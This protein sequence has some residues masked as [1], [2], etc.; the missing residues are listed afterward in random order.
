MTRAGYDPL[1]A[2]NPTFNRLDSLAQ[3]M[4]S[5]Y[6]G[7]VTFISRV[8]SGTGIEPVSTDTEMTVRAYTGGYSLSETDG[9]LIQSGDVKLIIGSEFEPEPAMKVRLRDNKTYDVISVES[10]KPDGIA[11]YYRVQV[12]K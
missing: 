6:G 5:T 3:R 4:I 9:E 11:I 8:Q 2:R 10:T 1:T 7:D 12:R